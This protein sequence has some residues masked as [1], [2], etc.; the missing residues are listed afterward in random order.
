MAQTRTDILSAIE[1]FRGRNAAPAAFEAFSD[2][3][4]RLAA[5]DPLNAGFY[6]MLGLHA[7]SFTERYEGHPLT[8]NVAEDAKS[9]IIG[10]AERVAP[11][12]ALNPET[13]LALLNDL[14]HA[15]VSGR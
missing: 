8:A 3:C 13:K 6:A 9:R 15:L 1:A 11:A 7:K 4:A 2:E 10:H 12:L 14:A 5:A